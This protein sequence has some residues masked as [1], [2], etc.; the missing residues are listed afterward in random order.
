MGFQLQWDSYRARS[1]IVIVI[2][3]YTYGIY[4]VRFVL[5]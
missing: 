3:N 2:K 5:R 4:L 1:S